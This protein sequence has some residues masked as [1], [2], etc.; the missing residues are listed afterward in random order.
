VTTL[1]HYAHA[2]ARHDE[3]IADNLDQVLNDRP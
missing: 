3:D 1:R 2:V